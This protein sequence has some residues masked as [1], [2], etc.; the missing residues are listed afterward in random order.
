MIIGEKFNTDNYSYQENYNGRLFGKN[1]NAKPATDTTAVKS[2]RRLF[3]PAGNNFGLFDKNKN[4]SEKKPKR[5]SGRKKNT[6]SKAEPTNSSP[7]SK[8][9]TRSEVENKT[10]PGKET[11][12]ANNTGGAQQREANTKAAAEKT[13]ASEQTDPNNTKDSAKSMTEEEKNDKDKMMYFGVA[14]V[15]VVILIIGFTLHGISK[16][17]NVPTPP[18]KTAA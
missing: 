3:H 16:N 5:H 9:E 1:K 6:A 18:I 17:S 10:I 11:T 14:C 13:E 12:A 8:S 4:K 7:S 15:G 2:K